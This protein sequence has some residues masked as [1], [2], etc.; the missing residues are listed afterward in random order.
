MPDISFF[1]GT[2][3]GN[4]RDG[5]G[6]DETEPSGPWLD[7]LLTSLGPRYVTQEY[8][9]KPSTRKRDLGMVT[10]GQYAHRP[11]M[12][13]QSHGTGPAAFPRSSVCLTP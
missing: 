7:R 11:R 1:G 8:F 10:V 6:G 13:S 3:R 4:V 2:I 9:H 5:G 12:R